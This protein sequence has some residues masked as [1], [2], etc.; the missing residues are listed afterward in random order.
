[1]VQIIINHLMGANEYLTV[2]ILSVIPIAELRA[3]IIYASMM[4]LSW[5][6]SLIISIIGNMLPIPF[7]IILLRPVLNWLKKTKYFGNIARKFQEKTMKK[8]DKVLKYEV[9]GLF[10]FVAIPLPGTGGWTGAAIA[11]LLDIRLKKA[12][13]TIFLGI[14]VAGLIMTVICRGIGGLFTYFTN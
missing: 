5:W 4:N 7:I 11:A 13:P 10:L 8:A 9:L 1:M 3:S 12:I 2:F 6:I 14:I